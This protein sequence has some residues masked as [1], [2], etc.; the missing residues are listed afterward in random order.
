MNS[1]ISNKQQNKF[2]DPL[3]SV[4]LIVNALE[5][6]KVRKAFVELE[7]DETV[8]VEQITNAKSNWNVYLDSYCHAVKM[9]NNDI[10]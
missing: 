5:M 6:F 10:Q 3:V 1:Q 9:I 7:M 2:N 4:A 8:T